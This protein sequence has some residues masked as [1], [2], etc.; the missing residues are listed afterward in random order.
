M[1]DSGGAGVAMRRRGWGHAF[2]AAFVAL[3]AYLSLA[4]KAP[5]AG[6]L[7]D[8]NI[9]HVLAYAW[10]MFWYAQLFV[11]HGARV[12]VACA[13][14]ALG[15]S[16]EYLQM[17]TPSRHFSYGDMRDDALGVIAGW[18]FAA[19]TDRWTQAVRRF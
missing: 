6:T 11:R 3:V 8:I 19:V 17:L 13:V 1:R 2:G 5:D 9:G 16:L 7:G 18:L 4:P 12:A 10:L 15:I 14:L